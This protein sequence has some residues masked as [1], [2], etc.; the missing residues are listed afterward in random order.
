MFWRS[1]GGFLCTQL[2]SGSRGA[3]ALD[4]S[5][6]PF[7]AFLHDR[8]SATHAEAETRFHFLQGSMDVSLAQTLIFYFVTNLGV[9]LSHVK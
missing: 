8:V 7:T 1:S 2:L 5:S 6:T 9:F 3:S 4:P